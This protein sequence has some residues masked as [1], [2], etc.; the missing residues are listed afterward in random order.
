MLDA[1]TTLTAGEVTARNFPRSPISV[2]QVREGGF[3][4]ED[5]WF[6]SVVARRSA[7][8]HNLTRFAQWCRDRGADLAPHGK[9]T[10]SPQL[11][12]A[13]LDHG[14][15]GITAA[16][17]AQARVMRD[18]GISRVLIANEILDEGPALWLAQ[19]NKD[20]HLDYYCLVDSREG[21]AVLDDAGRAAGTRIPVL[22]E[23]GVAGR[24]TGVR[25][26]EEGVALAEQ[27]A[28]SAHVQLAGVEGYEGVHPGNRAEGTVRDVSTWLTSLVELVRAIDSAGGFENVE[29]ILFTAGGSAFPDL[30]AEALG[31]ISGVSRPVRPIVRS[32]CYLTHDHQSYER[33]SPLRSAA[34]D[35]PLIPA[36]TCLARVNSVPEPGV[37]L[38]TVGKRDVPIDV[39]LP[40]ILNARG[41]DGT[42]REVGGMVITELNDHHAFVTDPSS[43]LRPGDLVEL[44][45]SHPCTTFDKWPL[46]PVLDDEDR[47]VD[48]IRTLF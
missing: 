20:P 14:A 46:I 31:G 48:A 45:L 22:V 40:I 47:V 32:G 41:R 6:P 15:W 38:L 28:A 17:V 35:D 8:E 16:T 18:H 33:S 3:A 39:D 29:E 24:R 37:A 27:V 13:Q 10:M 34:E 36:L 42:Q 44:G 25:S 7:L 43:A 30:A 21:L 4:C 19:A 9:T 11:W 23:L 12:Q 5:L 1:H 26:V 2:A